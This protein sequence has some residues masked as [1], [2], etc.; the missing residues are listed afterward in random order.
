VT[1]GVLAPWTLIDLSGLF[2]ASVTDVLP[3]VANSARPP[4]EPALGVNHAYWKDHITCRVSGQH[5]WDGAW[6]QRIGPDGVG[7]SHDGVPFRSPARGANIAVVTRAGG[8]R[9]AIVAPIRPRGR[10]LYL[11]VSGMTFPAQ[12]H[13]TNLRVTLRYDGGATQA[14]DLVNPTG[15]GDCWSNWC[16]RFHDTPANGFENLDGR[17]GTPGSAAPG[18]LARPVEVDTEAHLVKIPLDARQEL[19][20]LVL[21]A[22]A[23]DI[24][25]GLMGAS[26]LR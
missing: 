20:T 4:A 3:R 19:R 15:V 14:I 18:D 7:W 6:R 12:S 13:V 5:P 11:M 23:N 24:I 10:A 25:F 2:N 9:A 21:E 22:F 1:R 26:I 16:G 17:F 8:F